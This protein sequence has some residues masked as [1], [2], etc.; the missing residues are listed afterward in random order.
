MSQPAPLRIVI[1]LPGLHQVA[2][3]AERAFECIGGELARLGHEVTLLGAGRRESARGYRF[4]HVS[5]APREW[6]VHFPRIPYFR[7]PYAYEDFTFAFRLGR[8]VRALAADVTMTCNYP[9]TNWA[10]T[11]RGRRPPHV[12]VT[13]NGDHMLRAASIDYRRFRCEGLVCTNPA[14]FERHRA[15]LRSVMIPNGVDTAAFHPGPGDRS[16]FGLPKDRRLL[17]MVSALTPGK[18]VLEGIRAA[19]ELDDLA[20]VVAGDGELRKE[21]AALGNG[22]LPGRFFMLSLPPE[23]MPDLYRCAD[24]LLHMSMEEP[25]A[26]VYTEALASGLPIVAHDWSVTRWTLEQTAILV[27]TT[28]PADLNAAL[29]RATGRQTPELIE[30]RRQLAESRFGWP[31]IGKAY[32]DFFREVIAAC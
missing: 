23:K 27:D 22:L 19:A 29:R 32:A 9:Y 12:F 26:N 28:S 14:F 16:Q 20:L 24:A 7:S 15:Q 1:A 6:F 8:K 10:L 2:R 31:M 11:R 30:A 3:G 5:C 18:R 21:T 17:L 13:Q 25:S 4:I